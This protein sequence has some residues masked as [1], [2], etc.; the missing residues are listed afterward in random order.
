MIAPKEEV[1]TV[2]KLVKN[3]VHTNP[4]VDSNTL[5]NTPTESN[6]RIPHRF[7]DTVENCNKAV[8]MGERDRTISFM[9]TDHTFSAIFSIQKSMAQ[10]NENTAII[11]TREGAK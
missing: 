4:S 7:L 10:M 5:K 11:C 8:N 2:V 3:P 1:M 9:D 6:I